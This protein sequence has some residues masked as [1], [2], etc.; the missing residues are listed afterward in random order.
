MQEEI[1]DATLPE[2]D[3]IVPPKAEEKK[4]KFYDF[5]AQLAFNH[6]GKYVEET[7]CFN[8]AV[9]KYYRTLDRT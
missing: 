5:V 9:D 4:I 8:E 7:S 3:D 2:P 6:Q 1:K